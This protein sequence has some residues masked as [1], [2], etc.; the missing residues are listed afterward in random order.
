MAFTLDRV[1]SI[2]QA[3]G[4]LS[5]LGDFAAPLAA[6][7]PVLLVADPGLASLGIT[8][9]ARAALLQAGLATVL[10]E[11]L[12]SDPTL[13]QI[14][15]AAQ[16]AR[17]HNVALV[18]ALGGGSALDVG[19]A[20][21]AIAGVSSGMV[22]RRTSAQRPAPDISAASSKLGSMFRTAG[23]RSRKAVG[24]SAV[25]STKIMPPRP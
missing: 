24:A 13:A 7:Q 3:S 14:D 21:A 16:A 20:A 23:E 5:R 9:A 1:P 22:M 6:G 10:F 12:T 2:V 19:K 25:P 17:D 11:A 18:V 15:A 8:A 4:L